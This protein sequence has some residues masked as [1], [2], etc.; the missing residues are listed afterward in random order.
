MYVRSECLIGALQLD[1]DNN[2]RKT[3][4]LRQLLLLVGGHEM[5]VDL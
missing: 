4:H 1:I 5:N 2:K 3:G